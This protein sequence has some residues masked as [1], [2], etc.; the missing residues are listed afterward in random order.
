MKP[1]NSKFKHIAIKYLVILI[2]SFVY[3]CSISLFLE[4]N[5]LAPGG[6]TGI[7]I[8]INHYTGFSIG[9][10]Y[11]VINIPIMILGA[12]K[13]GF[14]FIFSTIVTIILNSVFVDIIA[15]FG[16]A[17]TDPLLASLFGGVLVAI[18]LGLILKVGSTSGG[19]DIIVRVLKLHFPHVE[20]G[21]LFMSIDIVIVAISAFAFKNI[22]IALYA[23]IACFVSSIV[24]D[25]VLY[26]TDG[27][28]LV[29]IISEHEAQITEKL[30]VDIDTGV[31]YV[32]GQGA[33][34]DLDK[35]IIMCVLKKQNLP[36]TQDIVR[37]I[38][39]NAF[40]II[41][42]A[43]EVVGKGYKSPFKEKI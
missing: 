20:T 7:S 30:L 23:A 33:Y 40:F 3:A 41:S 2:F 37:D 35:R 43:N 42:S 8:I 18:S 32:K 21:R 24:M 34:T 15:P 9:M 38:D 27:A 39:P 14:R 4:P 17:T 22:N 31:T 28:K 25:K 6:V 36:K 1:E 10:C 13:F 19:T 11:F 16:A 26:G 12:Y 29:F 5:N